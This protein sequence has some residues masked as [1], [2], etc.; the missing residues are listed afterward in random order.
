MLRLINYEV[1]ETEKK[2]EKSGTSPDCEAGNIF[3][4]GS[5][6]EKTVGLFQ[7]SPEASR[8]DGFC[9]RENPNIDSFQD[10]AESRALR[11]V[12]TEVLTNHCVYG[13][14]RGATRS[15]CSSIADLAFAVIK[16]LGEARKRQ[17]KTVVVDR[18]GVGEAATGVAAGFLPREFHNG[19][20]DQLHDRGFLEMRKLAAEL[21]LKSYKPLPG[22]LVR[23][24]SSAGAPA[25]TA[26]WLDGEVSITQEIGEAAQVDPSELTSALFGASGAELRPGAVRGIEEASDWGN[27]RLTGIHIDDDVERCDV[28]V[29]AMGPWSVLAEDWFHGFRVPLLGTLGSMAFYDR[30]AGSVHSAIA[31]SQQDDEGRDLMV[32][33]RA[34]GQVSCL[35]VQGGHKVLTGQ[36]LRQL[37]PEDVLPVQEDLEAGRSAFERLSSLTRGEAPKSTGAGV[38][39]VMTNRAPMIGRIPGYGGTAYVA[40]GHNA[41]GILCGPITGKALAEEILDGHSTCVDLTP[42]DPARH[43]LW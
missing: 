7:L 16:R 26:P 32:T 38:R 27:H 3:S 8:E 36:D 6:V 14:L 18:K 4:G 21:E 15:V 25:G 19:L 28:A 39:S 20:D 34:D 40:C 33:A 13:A 17:V 29:V 30:P 23:P 10:I 2:V 5:G 22:W 12:V 31:I 9:R 35:G 37:N 24:D 43:Q 11:E 1:T 42:F 41:Y